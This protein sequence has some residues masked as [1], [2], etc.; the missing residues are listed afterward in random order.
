M[1]FAIDEDK[2]KATQFLAA[3]ER[4][5]FPKL[6]FFTKDGTLQAYSGSRDHNDLLTL[7]KTYM[8]S[9]SP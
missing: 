2:A 7:Y 5:S 9:S 4:M 8:N 1:D 3:G 6:F